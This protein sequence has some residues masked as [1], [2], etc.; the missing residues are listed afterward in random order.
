MVMTTILL[1]IDIPSKMFHVNEHMT[2]TLK[3]QKE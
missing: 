2:S 1:H 3:L